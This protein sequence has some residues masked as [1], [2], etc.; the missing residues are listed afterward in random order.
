MT[1]KP[2][3]HLSDR[4]L[5]SQLKKLIRTERET[6]LSILDHLGEVDS[7]RLYLPMGY[8]TLFD[9]CTEHLKYSSSAAGRRIAAARCIRRFPEVAG[10]LQGREVNLSTIS[11]VARILTDDNKRELLAQIRGKSQREVEMVVASYKPR[12]LLRDRVKPVVVR[13]PSRAAAAATTQ[14]RTSASSY[15]RSGIGNNKKRSDKSESPVENTEQ[16]YVVQFTASPEFMKKV[17]EAKALL[18][19]CHPRGVS[20]E[21]VFEAAL[22]VFLDK[23]SPTKRSERRRARRVTKRQ[24]PKN[25]TRRVRVSTGPGN[26]RPSRHVSIK[27]RDMVYE[28]DGGRCTYKGSSGRRCNATHALQV[29]H[30]IPFGRGGGNGLSNLRLLC[31]R[32]NRL[33]AEQAYGAAAERFRRRE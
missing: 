27:T 16:R 21:N 12:V 20:F 22:D 2:L 6:T 24:Q 29:D 25:N 32:H 11:L 17:S 3:R 19:N 7:R 33:E 14:S 31:A 18:S 9:Y 8:G 10:L 26:Q 13:T 5:L 30:V 28:R 4:D 15:S 1:Q 23:N